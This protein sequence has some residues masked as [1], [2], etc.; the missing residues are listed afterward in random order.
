MPSANRKR[1]D[2]I[3]WIIVE[4]LV[5]ESGEASAVFTQCSREDVDR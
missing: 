5:R 1:Q 2:F 4:E 3:L